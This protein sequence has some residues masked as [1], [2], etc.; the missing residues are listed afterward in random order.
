MPSAWPSAQLYVVTCAARACPLRPA[1]DERAGADGRFAGGRVLPRGP[2]RVIAQLA[3]LSVASAALALARGHGLLALVPLSVAVTSFNFWRDAT[4]ANP[5]RLVDIVVVQLGLWT[6]VFVAARGAE[7]AR[8][9]FA[10]Y[11][12]GIICCAMGVAAKHESAWASASWHAAVHV[13]GNAANA[14]LFL[15]DIPATRGD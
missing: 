13:L 2:A 11:G 8:L 3:V 4:A 15:G 6:Q 14:A 10:L 5:W 9:F 12:V 1:A 7:N